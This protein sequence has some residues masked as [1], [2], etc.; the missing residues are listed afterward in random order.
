[1]RNSFLFLSILLIGLSNVIL[2]QENVSICE[3]QGPGA[4][5]QYD[6]QVVIT[7]GI[8]TA[9]F[10]ADDQLSGFFIQDDLCDLGRPSSK[11]LFV[12]TGSNPEVIE[13]GDEVEVVAE[14]K[15]FFD[16]TELTDIASL[17]ILSSNNS[18]ETVELS[19]PLSRRADLEFY[20]GMHVQ[21][22]QDLFVTDHF[23]LARFGELSLCS[24]NILPIPTQI[25]DPND[26]QVDGTNYEGSSNVQAI[27]NQQENNERNYIVMD[28][29]STRSSP[30]PTPYIN[31][32]KG[33][34][35]AGSKVQDLTGIL[36]Y[37]FDEY[38]LHPTQAPSIE[39]A[40]RAEL[41]SFSG[42]TPEMIKMCAF[43]VLNY[44]TTLDV[45]GATTEQELER[46]TN[47]LVNALEYIGA[48]V[49]GLMEIENN[50][51]EAYSALL[52]AF[53]ARIGNGNYKA[54]DASD[55]GTFNTKSVI[56]YN[57]NT[58]EPV[59]DLYATDPVQFER[60]SLAQVFRPAGESKGEFLF[61]VNHLR[62]KGCDGATGTNEDQ[63]DGQAC[64]NERRKN[65]V[66]AVIDLVERIQDQTGVDVHYIM[67]DMN[68]YYQEDPIDLFRDNGFVSYFDAEDFSY[69]FRG[70]WGAL[71]H[72]MLN[73]EA[74]E[75]TYAG[76]ILRINSMEPR[77]LDYQDDNE[78]F[79]Q[80]DFYRSSDHDPVII[81]IPYDRLLSS[82]EIEQDDKLPTVYP[83]PSEGLLNIEFEGDEST[84]HAITI[85]NLEGK[86]IDSISTT[87]LRA[88]FS[89]LPSATYLINIQTSEFSLTLP[90]VKQ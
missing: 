4:I 61:M 35:T 43:N 12:Y 27:W 83:N 46:Q 17:N 18:F 16:L 11:G 76:Q 57:A 14:V 23:N 8:V 26:S 69:V 3:I 58:V 42:E 38:R 77:F 25:V 1:M 32:A 79:Y 10:Q 6:G 80:D 90:W 29:G 56:F 47:K 37:S 67:G 36:S 73:D 45:W 30:S 31:P 7:K 44:F 63:N 40:D 51:S 2:A 64:F 70:E 71:D 24:V 22:A 52:A 20:E 78:P 15:E 82:P 49:Y 34:L 81:W 89:D 85:S 72:A 21:F 68:A 60:P 86:E 74:M 54:L 66:S 33:T 39:N 13:I 62:F 55:P 50:G 28:D 59:G 75:L 53:N 41:I 19:L 87:A 65:Q 5:S 9:D 48:D 84:I 88:N